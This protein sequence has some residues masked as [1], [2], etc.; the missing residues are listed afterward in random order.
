LDKKP[1]YF[2]KIY[3]AQFPDSRLSLCLWSGK[4]YPPKYFPPELTALI[5]RLILFSLNTTSL[6]Q[7]RRPVASPILMAV[8]HNDVAIVQ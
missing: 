6:L 4:P 7:Y 1:S 3:P 2:L 5:S 8:D